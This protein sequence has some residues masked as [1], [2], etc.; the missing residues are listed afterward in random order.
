MRS[1][2]SACNCYSHDFFPSGAA[3]FLAS[4]IQYW[5]ACRH[6]A[7]L[8]CATN[9]R[10]PLTQVGTSRRWSRKLTVKKPVAKSNEFGRFADTFF[11]PLVAGCVLSVTLSVCLSVCLSVIFCAWMGRFLFKV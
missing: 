9:Q 4:Q 11:F 7:S 3:H 10:V 2:R 5:D 8:A 1:V 6:D